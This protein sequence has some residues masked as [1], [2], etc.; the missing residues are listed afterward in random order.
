[1]VD[2][3]NGLTKQWFNKTVVYEFNELR[4]YGRE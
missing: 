2:Q 4:G 3:N 1:M